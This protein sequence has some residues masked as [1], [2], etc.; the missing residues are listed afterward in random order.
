LRPGQA[1]PSSMVHCNGSTGTRRLEIEMA[2]RVAR[3][4]VQVASVSMR[5]SQSGFAADLIQEFRNVS[6]T[7][8]LL[9]RKSVHD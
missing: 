8:R 6:T 1:W 5:A 9:K 3:V 7:Y 2:P 4:G